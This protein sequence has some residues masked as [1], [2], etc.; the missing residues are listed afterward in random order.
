MDAHSQPHLVEIVAT[1]REITAGITSATDLPEAVDDM[2]KVTANLLPGHIQCGVTLIGQGE[3]ATFAAVGLV[4]EV[5][6]EVQHGGDGP[7]M[8]AIRTR[9]IVISQDLA[10]DER[11]PGWSGRAIRNGVRSVLAYPFDVDGP[12]LG[13]FNLY[14]DRP[15]AFTDEISLIAMLVAD[16]ASLLLRARLRQTGQEALLAQV[17]TAQ[18]GDAAVERAIGIV[19]AQRGCTPDQALHH[20]HDAATHLGVGLAV[21]AERLVRTVSDRGTVGSL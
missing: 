10:R 14:A 13:G 16:H 21:L 4:P 2:L 3:P 1:L 12:M 15:R 18:V 17:T 8:E 20:L 6:D 5:L 11:W 9:D 19:M 7:C